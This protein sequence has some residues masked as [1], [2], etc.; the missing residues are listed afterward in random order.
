[1]FYKT[2]LNLAIEK[3]NLDI[4]KLLI[5][6]ENIDVNMKSIITQILFFISFQIVF[7]M[8]KISKLIYSQYNF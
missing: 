2:A 1:M 6:S 7:I 3:D 8:N 5:E 4:V